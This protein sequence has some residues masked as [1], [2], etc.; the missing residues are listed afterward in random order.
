MASA[1][2]QQNASQNSV[3]LFESNYPVAPFDYYNKGRIAAYGALDGY[4]ADRISIE[5]NLNKYTKDKDKVFLFQYLSGITD[6]S[7]LV[8]QELTQLGFANTATHDFSGVGFVYE[9]VR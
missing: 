4:N 1:Y 5:K 9:F 2:V 3:V 6:P 7:G 8:F